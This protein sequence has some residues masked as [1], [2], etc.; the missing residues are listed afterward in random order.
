MVEVITK[1]KLTVK[2]ALS[3]MI[4]SY[5]DLNNKRPS[6]WFVW[7]DE[8]KIKIDINCVCHA[9]LLYYDLG[10]DNLITAIPKSDDVS[11][12]YQRMLIYGP[13]KAFSDLI[14]LKK[15]DDN[16]YSHVTSLEDWPANVL[17]N[18]CIATRV[19]IE[20]AH[21][22]KFWD[23]KVKE[24]FNPVLAF[25]LSASNGG[26]E[27]LNSRTFPVM[28][29][30]WHDIATDW[31][32]IIQGNM[33]LQYLSKP[34]KTDPKQCTPSN[35]IWGYSDSYKKFK[36]LT[37]KEISEELG[38]PIVK[39]AKAPSKIRRITGKFDEGVFLHHLA[40]AQLPPVMVDASPTA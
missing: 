26:K 32:R 2:K 5:P 11:L 24:G 33:S 31:L 14:S 10:W 38:L 15:I 37:D 12:A 19:P 30:Y 23:L 28:G 40:Q 35:C 34:F 8:G 16:Y 3:V 22:L 29:H 25:L 7:N 18:Y 4:A 21:L 20:H 36:L 39:P 6:S 9:N 13:F 17:F 27:F 1:E